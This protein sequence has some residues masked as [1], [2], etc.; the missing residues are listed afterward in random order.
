[1]AAL[2][3]ASS[4]PDSVLDFLVWHH[5][6][7]MTKE[8]S[9]LASL[10]R[11]HFSSELS[12]TNLALLLQSYVSRREVSLTRASLKIPVLNIVGEQ[13]PHVEAT[14][15]LNMKVDPANSTWMKINDA[16]MVLDEQPEKVAEAV[17]LFLQGLG[18]TLKVQRSKSANVRPSKLQLKGKNVTAD[19][20]YDN[21]YC[22]KFRL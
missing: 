21:I 19:Q 13:S 11:N 14:I 3:R 4:V 22:I 17:S 10:Y 7:T 9:G 6:G 12:P 1:M 5:L 15:S 8:R 20:N 2:R 18:H 16:G